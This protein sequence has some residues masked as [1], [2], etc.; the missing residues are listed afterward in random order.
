MQCRVVRKADAP[1]MRTIVRRFFLLVAVVA[2]T[3]GAFVWHRTHPGTNPAARGAEIARRKGCFACHGV[4]GAPGIADPVSPGRGVPGWERSTLASYARD[5]RRIR[6]WILHGRPRSEGDGAAPSLVPMPAYEGFLSETEVADLVAYVQASAGGSGDPPEAAHQGWRVCA[7]LGCFGCHGA[8]G[9]GGVP[10]PGSLKGVIPG[11][12][13]SDYA[14]LV[15]DEAELREWILTGR[16]QRLWEN[17]VARH[18]LER[19]RI[20]MPAY[21]DHLSERELDQVIA[22]VGWLRRR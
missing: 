1:P 5:P 15:Q 12:L 3:A 8:A 9:I 14:E 7:R 19:Q 18:F 13:D 21:A 16:V 17:P 4:D 20:G 11:W 6:E 22:Y 10:N 2:A